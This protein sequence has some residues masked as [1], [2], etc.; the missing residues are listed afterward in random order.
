[1][2][3]RN[4]Q[5]RRIEP[6]FEAG[7]SRGTELRVDSSDRVLANKRQRSATKRKGSTQ[8]GSG[9]PGKQ[10][11]KRGAAMPWLRR[12]AYWGLVLSIWVAIG[13][14]CLVA[15]YAM[16]LPSMASWKVPQRP[17][18]ARI[19]SVDG[20]LIANR[21]T[22]GGEA[23]RLDEMSA[24]LP[25][26]VIAIEDRRFK[27]HSGVDP[28]GL[29]RAMATNLFSGRLVQGG[30]TLTQQLAKNLFLEPERTLERKVQEAVL[31][32]WLETQFTKDQILEL[33]LNRVYFGAGAYGVDA[34]ARRYFAKSA[35]DI[36]LGEAATL[37]GLLKAPSRLSPTRDPQAAEERAQT[38]L[39]AMRREGFITDREATQAMAMEP[40]KAKRYRSG[41]ENYVADMIMAQLPALIGDM[42]NDVI[43][44]TTINLDL[45]RKAGELVAQTLAAKG[46]RLNVSQGALVTMDPSGAIRALVGG[47]DYSESQFNRAVDAR[48]QPGSAFKPFVYLAA[49]EAGR[50]PETLR[51][52]VP[53][54]FGKWTPENYDREY[55][56]AVTLND[57][58][59]LSLN[60]V[61]AQLAMEVGPAAVVE[62][63]HRL[64]VKSELQPNASIALGTS[65]VSLLELA[66]AYA[67]FANG[68][69]AVSPFLIR[70]VTTS[71][72]DIL[73]ERGSVTG[74]KVVRSG[75]IGM[76]NAMLRSVIR[77]G[78]GRSAAF[79]GRDV[80]GKTG[81]TD[82][83]RD[84]LFVGYTTSLVTSV[85]FGN[86]DGAPMKKVT[87]GGLP[88]ETFSAF[89]S[90]AHEGLP[91][92]ALPGNYVPENA[93]AGAA[94]E[95]AEEGTPAALQDRDDRNEF[96]GSAPKPAAE[97]GEAAATVPRRRNLF[98][99][100]FGSPG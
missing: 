84:A 53:V 19:V 8:P 28:V 78:T 68:G 35:R 5:D 70:R 16:Q 9:K 49:M 46:D 88:A 91:P 56:G 51:Q 57:A 59:A 96:G 77:D 48:R 1:M 32:I 41:S 97:V 87:G 43:V 75:E 45:Q 100:L 69:T 52:D 11:K 38:V 4:S 13:L 26:A 2:A 54:R 63:A 67:P 64:G 10:S 29:G 37:A 71:A 20:E 27:L 90:A 58:L 95:L 76:M 17:P 3:K 83:S 92:S 31:A 18:N 81:T 73:Y 34:A 47:R 82:N 72:G 79:D 22:T 33:Y 99:L 12:T 94:P 40:G 65:E 66:A 14:S 24:W 21:G 7:P 23:M 98:E 6:R 60:T 61:A 36:T 30:S 42:R 86:D 85:W 44:S 62:T 50:T 55:R 25:L 93:I 89:M 39:A 80:A 15:Y 74:P